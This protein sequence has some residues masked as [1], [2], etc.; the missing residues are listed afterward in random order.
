LIGEVRA[1]WIKQ[2]EAVFNSSTQ[3]ALSF[4]NITLLMIDATIASP[5]APRTPSE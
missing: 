3:D 4:K 1:V 5:L 2:L